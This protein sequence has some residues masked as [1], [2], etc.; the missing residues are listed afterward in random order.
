MHAPVKG[1]G[2]GR[3]GGRKGGADVGL[4]VWVGERASCAVA[5]SVRE[6]VG[7]LSTVVVMLLYGDDG[8]GGE[9]C[10]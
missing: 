4:P 8:V 1:R 2:R 3:G 7:E 9:L 6:S 5:R 10:W